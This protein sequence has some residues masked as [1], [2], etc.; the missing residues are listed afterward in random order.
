MGTAGA[1]FGGDMIGAGGT[2]GGGFGGGGPALA[3]VDEPRITTQEKWD[4][5]SRG[6]LVQLAEGSLL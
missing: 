6:I 2:G 3:T 1:A 4:E 5:T